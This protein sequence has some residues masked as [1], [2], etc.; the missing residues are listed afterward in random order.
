MLLSEVNTAKQSLAVKKRK[1][2]LTNKPKQKS[3]LRYKNRMNGSQKGNNRN[4]E[5]AND[6][7]RHTKVP[8]HQKKQERPQPGKNRNT[9]K[10][11]T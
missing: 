9:G 3:R 4:A 1:E 2:T 11:T 10:H 8:A 5:Q 7:H 6:R